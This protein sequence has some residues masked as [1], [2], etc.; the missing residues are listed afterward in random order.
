MGRNK[1]ADKKYWAN[2]AKFAIEGLQEAV[3]DLEEKIERSEKE[4]AEFIK[5]STDLKIRL[6]ILKKGLNELLDEFKSL[7]G[8]KF[9]SQELRNIVERE[10]NAKS[11]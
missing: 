8:I 3:N 2:E 4:I 7:E 1:M 11:S 10:I 5:F 9:D 6:E